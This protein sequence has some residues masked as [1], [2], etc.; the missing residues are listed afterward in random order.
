MLKNNLERIKESMSDV[1]NKTLR[2]LNLQGLGDLIR[3]RSGDTINA[4]ILMVDDDKNRR[5]SVLTILKSHH[6]LVVESADCA[7]ALSLLASAKFDLILLDMTLPDKSGL[8]VLKFLEKN[9]IDSKVMVLTGTVGVANIIKSEILGAGKHI[10][11]P[12]NPDDLLKSIEHILSQ[13]SQSNLKLQLVKAGDFIKSTPTGNLD[14]NASKLGFAEIAVTGADLLDYTVLIDLRD[15]KSQLSATNIN[16]LASELVKYGKTFQRK[17]ALLVRADEN[18][19]QA[20][21]FEVAAHNLGFNVTIFTVFEDA[22][23]WLSS[24]A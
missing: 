4:K 15:V 20:R 1:A 13:R 19:D 24:I 8:R 9:H 14:M 2:K 17:T 7:N 23:I 3:K 5:D 21:L 12:Y 16:D 10:T 11:K 22:I 18:I 6:N